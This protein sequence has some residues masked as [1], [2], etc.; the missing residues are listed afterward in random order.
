MVN[1]S[2]YIIRKSKGTTVFG[3]II[4]EDFNQLHDCYC[5]FRYTEEAPLRIQKFILYAP[6]HHFLHFYTFTKNYTHIINKETVKEFWNIEPELIDECNVKMIDNVTRYSCIILIN[7]VDDISIIKNHLEY[8][9]K[10][11]NNQIRTF[12]SEYSNREVQ[13]QPQQLQQQQ[14]PHH[15]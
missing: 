12:F 3:R 15:Q 2:L 10:K 9:K 4:K 6:N 13:S 8:T 1:G 5:T 11:N 14:Q 7:K